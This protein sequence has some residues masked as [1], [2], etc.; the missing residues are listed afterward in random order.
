M[1]LIDYGWSLLGLVDPLKRT[2]PT[3]LAVSGDDGNEPQSPIPLTATISV[4]GLSVGGQYTTFRWDGT[5]NYP[6]DSKFETSN[7]SNVWK[8]V[9]KSATYSFE[10][11]NTIDSSTAVYYATVRVA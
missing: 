8:F 11:S 3:S 4:R 1:N 6:T 10:D 7:F 9:A 2:I 5:V